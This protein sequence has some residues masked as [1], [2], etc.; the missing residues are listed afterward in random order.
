MR[1]PLLHKPLFLAL[2]VSP[3]NAMDR[4]PF[5]YR[6]Y[7]PPPWKNAAVSPAVYNRANGHHQSQA[8]NKM[9]IPLPEIKNMMTILAKAVTKDGNIL[10]QGENKCNVSR[11]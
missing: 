6:I 1:S 8:P 10:I 7:L 5:P 9:G 2:S 11:I 4:I 3:N